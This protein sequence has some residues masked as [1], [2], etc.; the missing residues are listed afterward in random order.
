MSGMTPL[1]FVRSAILSS[2]IGATGAVTY[3]TWKR[4]KN[5]AKQL[6]LYS[7]TAGTSGLLVGY[8]IASFKRR[9][10]YTHGLTVGGN[11]FVM[12]GAFLVF[13]DSILFQFGKGRKQLFTNESPDSNINILLARHPVSPMF[14]SAVSGGLTGFILS[15]VF[16]RGPLVIASNSIQG[17]GLGVLGQFLYDKYRVW[18]LEKVLEYNYPQLTGNAP[19]PPQETELEEKLH[20]SDNIKNFL[21][22]ETYSSQ[23]NNKIRHLQIQLELLEEEEEKL[24]SRLKAGENN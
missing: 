7:A 3:N 23:V 24:Q 11:F 18:R 9:N 22:R 17:I 1:R 21:T 5:R 6:L 15:S 12:T 10:V 16:W 8:A 13:R 4:D 19:K 20:W 14:A 2:F